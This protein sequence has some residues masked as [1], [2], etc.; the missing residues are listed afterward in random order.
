MR[1]SLKSWIIFGCFLPVWLLVIGLGGWLLNNHFKALDQQL[2]DRGQLTLK[3]LS[4]A[5]AGGFMQAERLPQLRQIAEQLLEASDVRAFSLYDQRQVSLFHA[6]PSMRPLERN[7]TLR[8]SLQPGVAKEKETLRFIEP[9]YEL[10]ILRESP[11]G[12]VG[13]SLAL[14]GWAELELSRTPTLLYKYRLLLISGGLTT[15]LLLFSLLLTHLL[16]RYLQH[17]LDFS[18]EAIT[19]VAEGV[20]P[21]TLP[22]VHI[23]ELHQLQQT[24]AMLSSHVAEREQNYRQSLEE[25]RDDS[26][27]SLETIEIKNIELDRARKDALQASRIKSEFLAN[28]S[29][30]IRTPLNGIIG[31]SNVLSRTRL[32]QRQKEY[33]SLILG[34]SETMLGIINDILDFSK[35]EAGMM[36]L[37]NTPVNLRKALHESLAMLAPQAH[38]QRLDLLGLVYDDVPLEVKTDP[39]RFKQ[40]LSNLISNAIK[41]TEQGEVVVRIMLD[42]VAEDLEAGIPPSDLEAGSFCRLRFAVTDTG[43]G[44]NEAQRHKLFRA[45]SQAD[46][47]QTHQF[48]GTGL[49]LAICKQLVKQMG[50][51]IDLESVEGVGSTFWFSLPLQVQETAP[52]PE[53][54]LLGKTLGVL[55]SHRLTSQAWCHQLRSWRAQ[56]V[57]WD[58]PE[59]MLDHLNGRQQIAA[60]LVGLNA[61]QASSPI[62]LES[63][64]YLKTAELPCLMLVNSS[65]PEVHARLKRQTKGQ[66]L[67]KPLAAPRLKLALE[68]LLGQQPE[69]VESFYGEGVYATTAELPLILAVDDT[70]SNLLL[71]ITLLQQMGF[72]TLQATNGEEAV[73]RV[74]ENS[75]DLVLMDIQMPVMDGVQATRRIRSMGHAYR[76]LPILALTAHA[77]GDE[78]EAWMQAGINDVL[79]KPLHE[80]Q[81]MDLLHRWLGDRFVATHMP[82]AAPELNHSEE[83]WQSCP[84]DRE[85]G[86]RLAAGRAEL[87]DEL[88]GLLLSSLDQSREAIELA[89][90]R[91]DDDALIEAVHRLHGASRYCG[92]PDLAQITEVLETQLKSGQQQLVA[93]SL[94]QLLYEIDRLQ[95]WREREYASTWHR[96]SG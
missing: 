61:L 65:E 5:L 89:L 12:R 80:K 7:P 70:P 77:I 94:E 67:T 43:I 48:G 87:A 83:S 17:R 11:R 53:P 22:V 4:P 81:L 19:Q 74:I 92:V 54:W 36:I 55:E 24:I 15:G 58:T 51:Q 66:L 84:V 29:H 88:L 42:D 90:K 1:L 14:V 96:Q 46:T 10:A 71:L 13:D 8:W 78:K 27:R 95:D 35:I 85:L 21:E 49:G 75:V 2:V 63:L 60:V 62:W 25:V 59:K 91:Q 44:L 30:E 32:E 16:V 40:L 45:F 3:N 38:R 31:F 26:L 57:A 34:A 68:T 41:F 23:N 50:G 69:P 47:S 9:I 82:L 6:G 28:M 20:T 72:R 33:L 93:G 18:L 56:V 76:T 39:L 37:D 64:A 79:I 73:Q 52:E 86:I